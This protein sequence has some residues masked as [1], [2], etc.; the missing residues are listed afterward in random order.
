MTM[1]PAIAAISVITMMTT[2]PGD[3]PDTLSLDAPGIV[4][5]APRDL[6][7]SGTI[8]LKIDV[9]ADMRTADA[10]RGFLIEA[11]S[12]ALVRQDR[13]GVFLDSAYNPHRTGYLDEAIGEDGVAYHVPANP[14]G[15]P[16]DTTGRMV[17]YDLGHGFVD[18]GSGQYCLLGGFAKWWSAPQVI[19]IRDLSGPAPTDQRPL[20]VVANTLASSSLPM[21][22]P[23]LAIGKLGGRRFLRVKLP[24]PVVARVAET[25]KGEK[26]FFTIVGFHL[27]THGGAVGGVFTPRI[28]AGATTGALE[29]SISFAAF[30]S[31]D[32]V[33]MNRRRIPGHWVFLLFYGDQV[34]EPLE[35]TLADTDY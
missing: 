27:Q 20:P 28:T 7:P 3:A 6:S 18:R 29:A 21:A 23:L 35:V 12:L 13:P 30:A 16:R 1:R 10:L 33:R 14:I 34:S 5:R 8:P 11:V 22:R 2:R 26:P 17:E 9:E 4:I 32:R 19:S 25:A 31:F 15:D 24:S